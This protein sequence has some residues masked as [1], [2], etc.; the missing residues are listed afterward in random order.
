VAA[1]HETWTKAL[2]GDPA[3]LWDYLMEQSRDERLSLLAHCIAFTVDAVQRSVYGEG[4]VVHADQLVRALAL[5]MTASWTPTAG[6]YLSRVSKE[7]ILEAVREGVSPEAADN[8]AT[9]PKAAMAE[10]AEARLAGRGWLPAPLRIPPAPPQND[11][12]KA[13]PKRPASR[14]ARVAAAAATR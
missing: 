2:P 3:A 4:P 7:R 12:G 11:S 9:L 5:D 14:R 8:I 10:A 13:E 6:N 1:R